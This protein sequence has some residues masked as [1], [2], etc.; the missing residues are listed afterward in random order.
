[1]IVPPRSLTAETPPGLREKADEARDR[2]ATVVGLFKEDNKIKP[3][4][5]QRLHSEA[6]GAL[7]DYLENANSQEDIDHS[8]SILED[9]ERIHETYSGGK[10]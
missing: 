6:H 7:L 3:E 1:M 8:G 4:E 2:Y 9:L 10:K 5:I